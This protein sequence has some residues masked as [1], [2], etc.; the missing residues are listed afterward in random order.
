VC[1]TQAGEGP[2]YKSLVLAKRWPR[3]ELWPLAEAFTG[4]VINVLSDR[5]GSFSR[6]QIS[7]PARE[8][9]RLEIIAP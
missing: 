5:G 4:S 1:G 8:D 2:R 6:R 3:A 7:R 9:W